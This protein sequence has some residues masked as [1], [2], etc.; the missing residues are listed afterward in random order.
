MVM[1]AKLSVVAQ[2]NG[3]IDPTERRS[4]LELFGKEGDANWKGRLV[5]GTQRTKSGT[6]VDKFTAGTLRLL[7]YENVLTHQNFSLQRFLPAEHSLAGKH[8][9]LSVSMPTLLLM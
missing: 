3:L 8:S 6:G 5:Q 4:R 9:D 1:Y 2:P 7:A